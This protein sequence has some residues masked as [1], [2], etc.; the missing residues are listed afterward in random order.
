MH[1]KLEQ[2][3][4]PHLK[5]VAAQVNCSSGNVVEIEAAQRMKHDLSSKGVGRWKTGAGGTSSG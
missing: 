1:Q 4:S 5:P 3:G 2:V